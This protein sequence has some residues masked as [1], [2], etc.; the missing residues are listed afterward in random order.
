MSSQ[1]T[2]DVE[3]NSAF[4][5]LQAPVHLYTAACLCGVPAAPIN[6]HFRYLDLACGNGLTLSLLADAYPLA[7]FVGIDINP[8]HIAGARKRAAKAGLSNLQF[9]EADIADLA[10]EGFEPF[11]YC[12]IS[13]VYSWLDANRRLQTREFAQEVIKPGGLVY[14][15]YSSQPG[16]AQTAPLYQIL[17]QVGAVKP[18]DSSAKLS[19]AAGLL[20]TMREQGARFFQQNPIAQNRLS[21]IV[22]NPPKDEAHEVFN[23]QE[24]GLWSSEVIESMV[25]Q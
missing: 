13:G 23:L 7:D 19:A 22:S 14:L 16:M 18:G 3:F 9:I 8:D 11:D 24:F 1:Y 6:Q 21:G 5:A 15:D 20:D 25:Q 2:Q 12:A 17:K 4:G 10:A